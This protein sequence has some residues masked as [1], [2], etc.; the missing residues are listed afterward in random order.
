[1]AKLSKKEYDELIQ[2]PKE[3]LTQEDLNDIHEYEAAEAGAPSNEDLQWA[4]D[5][6][7]EKDP[8]IQ[9]EFRKSGDTDRAMAILKQKRNAD[10]LM[11]KQDKDPYI[12][13][14]KSTPEDVVEKGGYKYNWR[15]AYENVKG[16]QLRPTEAD[17]KKLQD[18]INTN[19]YN[20]DDDVKLKQ[21]AY[22]LHMYNPNTMKWSDFINSE[23][24]DEF[25][26]YLEDVRNAQTEQAVEDIWSGKD[27]KTAYDKFSTKA[28]DFMLPVSKEYARNHYND[29]DFSITGPLALDATSN[30]VMAGPT[31][32]S[33]SLP[34]KASD[35]AVKILRKPLVSY[36]YG[37]V[38]APAI[39]ETGN[40]VFNDESIPEAFMR[41]AEGTAINIGT[42]KAL[43]TI[44]SSV[45]RG[46]PKGD[47]RSVQKMIDQATNKAE[48]INR[49]MKKG[50]P[51]PIKPGK[52]D[53]PLE[54]QIYTG[55][56]K[57]NNA[58][59]STDPEASNK[60]WNVTS[61][62]S[63][64]DMPA[65]T[66]SEEELKAFD[67]GIPFS[68]SRS[69]K[70]GYDWLADAQDSRITFLD[71][72][73]DELLLRK[74]RALAKDGDL[75]SLSPSELRQLGFANKESYMNW[76]IR[77]FKNMT[78]E[79]VQSYLTN[80]AGRPKF[81]RS[82]GPIEIINNLLGTSL[83]KKDNSEEEKQKSRIERLLGM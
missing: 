81:G 19:M 32:L 58:L 3:Y 52:Q 83:F 27:D 49:D 53:G 2:V 9:A 76:L 62:K 72:A 71:S 42:P 40:V 57:K 38:A 46:L 70:E 30:L 73:R 69:K 29:E 80:A 4:R 66:I 59:Y 45:G 28:V 14:V 65:E 20:V 74:A 43:E 31:G 22:N 51:Y 5:I 33:A 16:E 15:N 78:P 54:F 12:M 11:I 13:K 82:A 55:N 64:K 44:L 17:A 10:D 25:K 35:A 61:F 8:Q 39:T 60:Y 48:K 23:Q 7:N 6:L 68:R 77:T 21:V 67:E 1:M 34:A 26:K 56:G 47:R 41:T 79:T 50:K 24:G 75:R 37:N 18:F 36:L 63:V